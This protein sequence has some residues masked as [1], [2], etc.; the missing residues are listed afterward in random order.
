MHTHMS[1]EGAEGE[2][3]SPLS[4]EINWGSIPGPQDHDLGPRQTLNRLSHPGVPGSSFL[5]PFS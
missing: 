2:A 3:D 5:N 4:R 1:G